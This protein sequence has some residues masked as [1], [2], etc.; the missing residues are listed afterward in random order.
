MSVPA[1]LTAFCRYSVGA[2]FIFSG[3]IKVNDPRGF[4]YKLIEYFHVF[5]QDFGFPAEVFVA[6]A[7]TIASLLAVFEV[8]LGI[9]LIMG[10]ARQFTTIALFV[11]ILFFTMLTFYSWEF[12]KVTDCGCFGDFLKLTPKQSFIKDVVLLAL[13]SYL[14]FFPSRIQPLLRNKRTQLVVTHGM[15]ALIPLLLLVTLTTG[16]AVDMLG[17]CK[18]CDFK[19]HVNDPEG[20]KGIKEWV[21]L[22]SFCDSDGMKGLSLIVVVNK[23]EKEDDALY[24]ELAATHKELKG[25]VAVFLTTGS[26]SKV[27]KPWLA[28]YKPDYCVAQNGVDVLKTII[29][30]NRG[31]L[32]LKDGVVVDKWVG[33]VPGAQA[34]QAALD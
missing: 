26:T 21:S 20:P 30:H 15:G 33:S 4:A 5:E 28:K 10:W 6:G 27:R 25:K 16:P 7:L 11:L 8:L 24:T 2:L 34:V 13:I 31:A 9:W 29:R 17:A 18:G 12:N 1:I 19:A 32:L 22:D 14:F 23:L 3:L